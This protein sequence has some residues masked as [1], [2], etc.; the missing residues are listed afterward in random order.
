MAEFPYRSRGG[1]AWREDRQA[2]QF[3]TVQIAK[4]HAFE[5]IA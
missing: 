2:Y 1:R 5:E 3:I 4:Q